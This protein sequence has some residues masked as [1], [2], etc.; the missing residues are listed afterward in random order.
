MIFAYLVLAHDAPDQL[1]ALIA[2]LLA[3]DA[4][5]FVILHVDRSAS[6]W[7]DAAHALVA[8]FGDRLTLVPRPVAVR[9][10]HR[11][12]VVAIQKLIEG[13]LARR[14]DTA[15]LISGRDW[16]FVA[17]TDIA[18]QIAAAPATCFIDAGSTAQQDRMQH[19]WFHARLL[20]PRT[21]GAA[22][23][24]ATKK[25]LRIASRLAS[26]FIRRS[27]PFGIWRK[28]HSWWSLPYDVCAVVAAT[29]QQRDV[30]R[31]LR[32][33]ACSDEHV[34]QTLVATR[35]PDR[36]APSQRYTDWSSGASSPAILTRADDAAIRASGAWFAR[37]LASETDDWFLRRR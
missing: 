10:G 21:E 34:I 16:R 4:R 18:R 3:Q 20:N 26:R 5:D 14:F 33:T 25:L 31:R 12:Q 8:Q 15:H 2:D 35:Y 11:S 32:F 6:L 17:R 30:A 19:W 37:K 9:W 24:R 22:P 36:I 7:P 27:Q 13:A 29:L 28:G 23:Y 1:E